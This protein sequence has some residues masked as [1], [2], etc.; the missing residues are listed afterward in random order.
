MGRLSEQ[1]EREMRVTK[2]EETNKDQ[3][4]FWNGAGGDI[5]VARQTHTDVTLAP[6]SKA[7]LAFA[8]PGRDE[9]VLDVGC[10][11]GATTLDFA[12][13]V[14]PDGQV[15][16]LDIS[17]PMLAEGARRAK[18]ASLSNINWMRADAANADLDEYDLLTSA[19][20]LMFF[21]D[22]V[23]AFTHMRRAAKPGARMA[24]VCWRSLGDNPWMG[25]P[26]AA[27][28]PHLPPRPQATPNAP[29]MFAFAD[30]EF[31]TDVLK[32]AGWTAPTIE[33]LDVELDIAAGQGL[34]AAVVQT[35]QIGA[36]NSWLRGQPDAVT[37]AAVASIHEAL[38]PY[39]KGE[40]VSLPAGM[41]L[42]SSQ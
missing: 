38:T 20:G 30:P 36:V 1:F 12:R 15:V 27:A 28:A 26:M 16:A 5:W 14:G 37:S 39:V 35:T 19:F 31:L 40:H 11:C 21:G 17:Q 22:P 33:R 32:S 24:F 7:L 13:A 3:Q 10:G 6:M 42:V 2:A 9:Y 41:W 18:I 25:V 29:G 34:D 8:A 4:A 23:S